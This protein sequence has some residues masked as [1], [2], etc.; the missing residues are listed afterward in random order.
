VFETLLLA[1][2]LWAL[3]F[4]TQDFIKRALAAGVI[5][6]IL[7]SIQAPAWGLVVWWPFFI[8]SCA[9][10]AWRRVSWVYAFLAAALLHFIQNLLPAI[11][12]VVMPAGSG[13]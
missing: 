1:F 7:H 6:G 4:V 10:L 5:W 11:A 12:V 2:T 3:S 13:T 9:Y 8:F